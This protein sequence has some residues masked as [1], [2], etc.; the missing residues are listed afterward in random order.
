MKKIVLGLLL[1]SVTSL[2][3]AGTTSVG[4]VKLEAPFS[5]AD[6]YEAYATDGRIYEISADNAELIILAKKAVEIKEEVEVELSSA[7][8]SEDLLELRNQI[9][10]IK[11]VNIEIDAVSQAPAQMVTKDFSNR[12][13]IMNDYISDLSSEQKLY[14]LF[15][16]QRRDTKTKSQCFNR[17]HVWSWELSANYDDGRRVQAG[18]TWIFFT[19]KYIR[20]YKYKWWFHITPYLRLNGQDRMMDRSYLTAPA[21]LQYWTDK[22]IATN[23]V[24]KKVNRYSDYSRNQ[25]ERNCFIMQ[26]SVHYWQPWQVENVETRNQAQLGWND[27]ELKKA[28]RDAIGWFAK[29]PNIQ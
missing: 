15:Q 18:K 23:E 14:N 25:N 28:Y 13:N 10:D 24:C 2:G 12:A 3:F 19:K 27:Y 22:F 29:V 17:A 20:G 4:I 26:T 21:S 7:A 6:A 16:G 9:L 5:R 8:G 11:F 1:C